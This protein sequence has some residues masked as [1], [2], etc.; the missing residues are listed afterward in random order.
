M[1]RLSLLGLLLVWFPLIFPASALGQTRDPIRITNIRFGFPAG[2]LSATNA[3]GQPM[4]LFK[5]GCW[6]PVFVDLTSKGPFELKPGESLQLCV[7]CADSSDVLQRYCVPLPGLSEMPAGDVSRGSSRGNLP[8]MKPGRNEL[9][10]RVQAGSSQGGWRDLSPRTRS[11]ITGVPPSDYLLLSA[12]ASLEKLRLPVESD[13]RTRESEVRDLGVVHLAVVETPEQLPDQWFGYSGIDQ[14]LLTTG[15]DQAQFVQSLFTA[16]VHQ[17]RVQALREWLSRGGRLIVSVGN[18]VETIADLEAFRDLLP[19]Q[20]QGRLELEEVYLK[21]Q[22][23]HGQQSYRDHTLRASVA[24]QPILLSDFDLKPERGAKVLLDYENQNRPGN[25]RLPLIVQ[26]SYGLG[27]IT[28]VGFDLETSPFSTWEEPGVFWRWLLSSAGSRLPESLQV[29]RDRIGVSDQEAMQTGRKLQRYLDYF[30]GIPVIS[31]GWVALFILVYILI[32]GPLEY[33]LL[34]RLFNR[35][36]WTWLTFPILVLTFSLAAYFTAFAIK[37]KEQK[38][39]KIDVVDIDL[40]QQR[41][42]GHTWF[43][44]FSPRI[45]NQNVQLI[46]SKQGW[47]TDKQSV[48]PVMLTW[49]GEANSNRTSLFRR[50]YDYWV[51]PAVKAFARG[52]ENVPTQ[53]WSTRAFASA[54]STSLSIDSPPVESSLHHPTGDPQ[55]IVG[56]ITSQLPIAKMKGVHLIYRDKVYGPYTLLRGVPQRITTGVEATEVRTWIQELVRTNLPAEEY[57]SP[58][59]TSDLPPKR[60]RL[61]PLLFH[62]FA[63]STGELTNAGF[64]MLDQ[65]WRIRA[66]NTSE[67]IL[68]ATLPLT[69]GDAAEQNTSLSNPSRLSLTR[70]PTQSQTTPSLT[71]SMRQET[72]LRVFI[73]IAPARMQEG[74]P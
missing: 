44:V 48:D 59:G 45:E 34:K 29:G 47:S 15:A 5:D 74:Q 4:P 12:G 41:L 26:G 27:Q 71:G 66:D 16:E 42:F 22:E 61:E 3:T 33:L 40:S 50:R 17:T 52:L 62:Q 37:G 18:H 51:D 68:V 7:E 20:L 23:I 8:Y 60:Y 39:N 30:S 69:E 11:P 67:V 64:R 14:L 36:E 25:P 19:V 57:Y 72:Y 46:P 65:S 53:V 24:E 73:P 63:R 38:I 13:S 10:V 35:L 56:S 54:W 58:Y 43:S 32:I 2:P 55:A 1:H 6:T 28:V 49:L 70:T 9:F 31:F 21:W